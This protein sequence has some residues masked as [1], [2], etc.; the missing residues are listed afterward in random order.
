[1][2]LPNSF[3]FWSQFPGNCDGEPSVRSQRGDSLRSNFPKTIL[4]RKAAST[5]MGKKNA[6]SEAKGT[7]QSFG[8]V[9]EPS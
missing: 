6:A 9:K 3:L 7:D 2:L 5:T 8:N 4:L 1:M